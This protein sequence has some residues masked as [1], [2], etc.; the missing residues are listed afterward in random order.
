MKKNFIVI[1]LITTLI[2]VGCKT[3]EKEVVIEVIPESPLEMMQTSSNNFK[4]ICFDKITPY[5]D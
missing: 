1:L 3:K 5:F 2:L 4:E